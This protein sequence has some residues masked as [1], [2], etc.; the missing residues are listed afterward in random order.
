MQDGFA[1]LLSFDERPLI[2]SRQQSLSYI[3]YMPEDNDLSNP[4]TNRLL[5]NNGA[6]DPPP[7]R[8]IEQRKRGIIRRHT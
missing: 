1:Q 4:N 7:L 3:N 6:K 5:R 8:G 2:V